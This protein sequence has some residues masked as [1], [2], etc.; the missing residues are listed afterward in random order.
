MRR[1][2][3]SFTLADDVSRRLDELVAAR[4]SDPRVRFLFPPGATSAPPASVS[5]PQLDDHDL[6]ASDYASLYK[7]AGLRRKEPPAIWKFGLPPQSEWARFMAAMVDLA[8]RSPADAAVAQRA[9]D[10][11]K[12]AGRLNRRA[13]RK[14]ETAARKAAAARPAKAPN[15]NASRVADAV[16]TLGFTALQERLATIE[17]AG[18]TKRDAEEGRA[19]RPGRKA[20]KN[21]AA[22]AI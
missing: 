11:S 16:L 18:R 9:L 4:P 13:R 7:A 2:I 1:A 17:T 22:G 6:S 10:R 20:G 15:A 14:A 19:Q 21:L 5:P 3:R 8:N 12:E